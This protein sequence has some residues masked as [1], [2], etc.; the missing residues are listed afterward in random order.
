M[1]WS[2]TLFVHARESGGVG[3]KVRAMCARAA[4]PS[5][6]AARNSHVFQA[7]VCGP[8]SPSAALRGPEPA[9]PWMQRRGSVRPG[10]AGSLRGRAGEIVSTSLGTSRGTSRTSGASPPIPPCYPCRDRAQLPRCGFPVKTVPVFP[11]KSS[12]SRKLRNG[13]PPPAR[14]WPP[15]SS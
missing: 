12:R 5:R 13:P 6:G 15:P 7:A 1:L 3:H 8:L 10:R 11:V 4:R 14:Y 9:R 2:D